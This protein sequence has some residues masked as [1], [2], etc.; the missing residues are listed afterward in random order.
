MEAMARSNQIN[1]V[2]DSMMKVMG[3][4]DPAEF[5]RVARD[6]CKEMA[7]DMAM[8]F[9]LRVFSRISKLLEKNEK[10]A[11]LKLDDQ[12]AFVMKMTLEDE[13]TVKTFKQA[14]EEPDKDEAGLSNERSTVKRGEGNTAFQKKKDTDALRLYTE[15]IFSALPTTEEGKKDI[16]LGLANRSA[17]LIKM[18]KQRECLEDIEAALYFDYPENMR[19]K[20]LD[21]QAKC[22]VALG[23]VSEA[24]RSYNR[25][26][27]LL[28]QSNLDQDKQ[29]KWRTETQKELD[30]LKGKEDNQQLRQKNEIQDVILLD[31]VNQKIPQFSDAVELVYNKNVG[32][33]GKATRDIEVGEV[34]MQDT[35]VTSHLLCS[36]R[37]TNCTH[38]MKTIQCASRGIPSPLVVGCRFCSMPCLRTA[39]DSYH[40]VESKVNMNKFFWNRKEESYEDLSGNIL[41][42]YRAITQ[43][44]LEFFT[45]L[46]DYRAV[47]PKFAVEFKDEEDICKFSDYRNI[48]N[49][50]AHRAKRNTEER[51]S[52]CIRTA[53]CIV[54]LRHGGYFG[55]KETSYGAALS[56]Q[57]ALIA[58]IV[59]FMQEG[60]QY[61][62]HTVDEV[63]PSNLT[64]IA[65]PQLREVGCA[66][67]PTLLLLNHS[68]EP[69]TLRINANG[70]QVVMV[71]KRR[72]RQGEE[73]TDNYG[74][75]HISMAFEDRQD[76]LN[77]GFAFSCCCNGCAKDYPRLKSLRSQLPEKVEDDFDAKRDDVKEKFRKGDHPAC[78]SLSCDM[79]KLLEKNNIVYPHRNYELA[80]LSLLSCLWKIHGNKSS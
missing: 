26:V 56:T 29:D 40:P 8:P 39:M 76:A 53:I 25:S 16:S 46:E 28:K 31:K 5:Q 37:N 30:K 65:S 71:A 54:L 69:N 67:F 72:I 32:R 61:N 4:T 70:N 1:K 41:L 15:A 38:C 27:L 11:K 19:Y 80:A 7:M 13:D 78:L 34:I 57:E 75:H 23:Q 3:I 51:L 2:K 58:N 12:I 66:V 9:Y 43:K 22:Y 42:S 35:C 74:I 33:H 60:I 49:L 63:K 62:L 24:V 17:V 47:D 59:Y 36:T 10:Y 48:F 50:E 18:G 55:D 20:L 68:C 44:P 73:I 6:Y 21:R 14:F 64:G 45:S 77:R 52:L 79:I